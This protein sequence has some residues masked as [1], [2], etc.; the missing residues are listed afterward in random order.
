MKVSLNQLDFLPY[1]LDYNDKL[2][3]EKNIHDILLI[4]VTERDD[5]VFWLTCLTHNA[6]NYY[7]WN[8]FDTRHT[9]YEEAVRD[10]YDSLDEVLHSIFNECWEKRGWELILTSLYKNDTSFTTILSKYVKF[11]KTPYVD[12]F[13]DPKKPHKD[14]RQYTNFKSIVSKPKRTPI[15]R[16]KSKIK[17]LLET[18]QNQ[19][20][21]FKDKVISSYQCPLTD[22]TFDESGFDLD[23]IKECAV[24]G[25]HNISNLQL[26]CKSCH[27]V[28]TR[29]FMKQH[30]SR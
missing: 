28:K 2:V 9:Y 3:Q 11:I 26:L 21:N 12:C 22:G 19:C 6:K 1:Y 18:Q 5:M 17:L 8:C 10:I 15:T 24:G 4:S 29:R 25:T 30:L 23:H 20:A 16:K 14:T 13:Y 7:I 27:S